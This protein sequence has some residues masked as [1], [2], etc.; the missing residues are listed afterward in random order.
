MV[1]DKKNFKSCETFLYKI[2]NIRR[3][4]MTYTKKSEAMPDANERRKW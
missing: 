1:N 4:I 2:S 3:D